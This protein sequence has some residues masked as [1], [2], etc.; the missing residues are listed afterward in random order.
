MDLQILALWFI[1]TITFMLVTGFA[2][3]MVIKR[4]YRYRD[5]IDHDHVHGS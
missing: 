2:Y 4:R 5:R 1:I 3:S